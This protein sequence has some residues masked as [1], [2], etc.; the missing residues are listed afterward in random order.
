MTMNEKSSAAT[1]SGATAKLVAV[2]RPPSPASTDRA[3]DSRQVSVRDSAQEF[4]IPA[5]QFSVSKY[6]LM[7][8]TGTVAAMIAA[9]GARSG[10]PG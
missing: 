4:H 9:K 5:A 8:Q 10:V 1:P 3:I 6:Q 2:G 7:P